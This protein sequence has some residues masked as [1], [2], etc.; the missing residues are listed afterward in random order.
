MNS[1]GIMKSIQNNSCIL[2]SW[3][4]GTVLSLFIQLQFA[5]KY[6]NELEE[7]T[8]FYLTLFFSKKYYYHYRYFSGI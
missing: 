4:D 5:H 1:T 2:I 8:F 6:D 3:S 7:V